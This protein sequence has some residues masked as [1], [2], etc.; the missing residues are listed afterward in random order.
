MILSPLKWAGGKSGLLERIVPHLSGA[1]R[2]VE[3]FFG[4]GVVGA[5]AG[6][7][8]IA[9]DASTRLVEFHNVTRE[10]PEYLFGQVLPLFAGGNTQE[11]YLAARTEFNRTTSPVRRA[12]LF[13]YLNRHCFN[14]LY[15]EN[16]KGEFNVPF[17]S[18]TNVELDA[19]RLGEWSAAMKGIKLINSDFGA[20]MT[21]TEPGDVVYADPPYVPLTP[22]A[23]FTAYSAGGFGEPEQRRLAQAARRCQERGVKVVV[24]NHDTPL[25]RELYA[26]ARIESFPVRRRI[27][28]D[29]TNRAPAQEL[30]AV[31]D[32]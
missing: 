15:R 10:W 30:L 32:P 3:P 20:I 6:I 14:G 25:T 22:S 26:G 31:F 7:P 28:R 1:T 16:K 29:A 21:A 8:V 17:G 23:S 12:A 9:G 19:K 4:S 18:Y 11:R 24:S 27:S 5:N 2:L 13:L